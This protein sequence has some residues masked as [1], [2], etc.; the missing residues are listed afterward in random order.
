MVRPALTCG[1]RVLPPQPTQLL[2]QR[3]F[4]AM[5]ALRP[6]PCAVRHPLQAGRP[7][8]I[9]LRVLALPPALQLIQVAEDAWHNAGGQQLL[10]T[11][12]GVAE[13]LAGSCSLVRRRRLD[14]LRLLLLLCRIGGC[15][16]GRPAPNSP[17]Y[18]A[19]SA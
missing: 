3:A 18:V 11:P 5:D 7:S 16:L 9:T 6:E 4:A 17:E 12:R 8:D 14:D 19:S 15:A 13:R 2:L 1:K 10:Q